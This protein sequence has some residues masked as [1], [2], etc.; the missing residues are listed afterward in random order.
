MRTVLSL[1]RTCFAFN[2]VAQVGKKPSESAL[3]EMAGCDLYSTATSKMDLLADRL[4]LPTPPHASPMP[5]VSVPAV[6]HADRLNFAKTCFRT[7]YY[8]S[9]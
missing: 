1:R 6:V 3:Y 2:D 9:S 4:K 7:A 8:S 5:H